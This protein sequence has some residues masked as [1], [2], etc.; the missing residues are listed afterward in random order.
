MK[1]K[2]HKFLPAGPTTQL[3]LKFTVADP[4]LS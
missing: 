1:L 4:K 2:H 3:V